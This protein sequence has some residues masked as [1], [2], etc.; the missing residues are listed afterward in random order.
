MQQLGQEND[1]LSPT[2]T[3]GRAILEVQGGNRMRERDR[4]KIAVWVPE[5][6]PVIIKPLWSVCTFPQILPSHAQ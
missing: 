2:E 1:Y 6:W 5:V 4:V 3:D